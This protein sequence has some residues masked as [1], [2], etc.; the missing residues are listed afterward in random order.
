MSQPFVWTFVIHPYP[1]PLA[2]VPAAHLLA[3]DTS[4]WIRWQRFRGR[5]FE[6][7]TAAID[8]RGP[9]VRLGPRELAMK[10]QADMQY[11]YGVGKHN[12][13]KHSSYDV[14]ITQGYACPFP[15]RHY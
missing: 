2:S 15:P 13:D 5:E 10:S 12:L 6:V 3:N 1:S 11:V 7:I 14:F 8:K 9:Y 4:L